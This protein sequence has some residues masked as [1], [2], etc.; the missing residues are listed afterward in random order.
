MILTAREV[1]EYWVGNGGPRNR[2]VP[3]VAVAYGESGFNTR[4]LSAVGARGLWQFMPGSW[5][6]QCGP[7]SNA[8][9]PEA[10]AEATVILSGGGM[11]FAPWDSCYRNIYASGR[12]SF[13]GWPETG[14]VDYDNIP[15]VEAMIGDKS[16]GGLS[17]PIEPTAS[18]GLPN[19]LGWYANTTATVL[20]RLQKRSRSY[21]TIASRLY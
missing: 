14:S 21:G 3:W 20:P 13:L 19:A 7:F 16:Y 12:Y 2:A 8:W 4:A 5:P 17:S 15:I 11:N 6:I 1:A 18:S 9:L 10:N